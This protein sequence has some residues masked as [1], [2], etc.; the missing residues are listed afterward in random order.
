MIGFLL[1]YCRAKNFN[2]LKFRQNIFIAG[3]PNYLRCVQIKKKWLKQTFILYAY[4]LWEI[5]TKRSAKNVFNK[6]NYSV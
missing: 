3:F 4:A 5:F 1:H 6:Q 2:V